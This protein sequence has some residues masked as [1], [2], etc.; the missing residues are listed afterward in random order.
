M[1]IFFWLYCKRITFKVTIHS[2]R[3]VSMTCLLSSWLL[4]LLPSHFRHWNKTSGQ[5]CLF[6]IP[7][8]LIPTKNVTFNNDDTSVEGLHTD[9]GVVVMFLC[10]PHSNHLFTFESCDVFSCRLLQVCVF[11]Q[12]PRS[13][14]CT[15]PFPSFR[16]RNRSCCC[17]ESMTIWDVTTS[18][19]F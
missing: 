5:L 6:H 18:L 19:V 15:D 12:R 8:H 1:F 13:F 14:C 7:P 9:V 16:T 2:I 11:Q 10:Q 4:L 17:P 3:N